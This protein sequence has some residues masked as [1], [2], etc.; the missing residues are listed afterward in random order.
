MVTCEC[1]RVRD[2]YFSPMERIILI[3]ILNVFNMFDMKH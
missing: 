3:K 2:Y 1:K